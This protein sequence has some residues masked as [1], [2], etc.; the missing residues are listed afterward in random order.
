MTTRRRIT[1]FTL[2]EVIIVVAIIG[3]LSAVAIPSYSDHVMRSRRAEAKSALQQVALWMERNQAATFRYDA[4][5]SGATVSDRTLATRGW[6]Q[7]PATGT[8]RYTIAFASGPTTSNFVLTAT[9]QG[10]QATADGA[11]GGPLAIDH[12]GQRGVLKGGIVQVDAASEVCW[13]R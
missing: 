1:G 7:T 12:I 3:I 5:P 11:C 13:Q 10:A 2:V 9:P 4:D 8:A 6:G